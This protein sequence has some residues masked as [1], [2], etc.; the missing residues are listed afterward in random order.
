[1]DT[2]K[3]DHLMQSLSLLWL[4]S[5]TIGAIIIWWVRRWDM[6]RPRKVVKTKTYSKRLAERFAAPKGPKRNQERGDR[7]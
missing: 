1:M 3:H 4:A 5:I 7:Q 6:R 2:D